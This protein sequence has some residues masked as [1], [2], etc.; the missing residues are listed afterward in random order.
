MQD[1]NGKAAP[2]AIDH[3][4]F[5][6]ARLAAGQTGIIPEREIA[7]LDSLAD[8]ATLGS[9]N[10]ARTGAAAMDKNGI[11]GSLQIG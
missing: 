9:E 5:Y 8:I 3:F 11:T 10:L 6:F 4:R 7:P 2:L 1:A